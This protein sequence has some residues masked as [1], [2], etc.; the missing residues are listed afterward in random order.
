MLGREVDLNVPRALA[1]PLADAV[2]ACGDP[3]E[4]VTGVVLAV[5]GDL[6]GLVLLLIPAPS[7]PVA[8]AACSASSRA[9]R[10]ATRPCGEIGNI[11]GASYLNALAAMTGLELLPCPP[12]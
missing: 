1:L 10:W 12:L 8:S 4:P 2:D 6:E 9:P 5:D 7:T 11:L 3:E